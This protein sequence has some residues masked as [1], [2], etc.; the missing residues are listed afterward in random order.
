MST[1]DTRDTDPH[2]YSRNTPVRF[3]IVETT[4]YYQ[5]ITLGE[6]EEAAG[7]TLVEAGSLAELV[8]VVQ[9]DPPSGFAEMLERHADVQ[10]QEWSAAI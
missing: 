9:D 8:R 10:G 3:L 5:T 2:Q 7:L 6:L 1:D 4:H